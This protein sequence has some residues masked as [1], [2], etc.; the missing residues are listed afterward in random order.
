MAKVYM[1]NEQYH[2]HPALGSTKLKTVLKSPAKFQWDLTHKSEPTPAMKF[3]TLFHEA[4]LEKELFEDTYRVMPDFY[5]RGST[6]QKE[7][8]AA[9]TKLAGKKVIDE[10]DFEKISIML[11]SVTNHKQASRL[12]S[13]GKSEDSY[14]ATIDETPLKCRPDFL[15]DGKIISDIKT[16]AK[17]INT[18]NRVIL[19]YGYHISAAVYLDVVSA[20][21]GTKYDEFILIAV[22]SVPPF[23]TITFLIDEGSIDAGRSLYKKAIRRYKECSL[24]GV[25]STYPDEIIPIAIP[26]WAFPSEE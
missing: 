25:W 4:V 2:E 8:W 14:F 26:H 12:L 1:S 18:F 6:V 20:E 24:S 9:R 5:G 19:D 17:D 11:K 23:E 7:E 13:C 22:Q 16:T 15:R 21:L 10:D 3:G